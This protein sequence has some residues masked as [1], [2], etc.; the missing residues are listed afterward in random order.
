M[1]ALEA[2]KAKRLETYVKKCRS[3]LE[4]KGW[5]DGL[6]YAAETFLESVWGPMFEYNF[7]SGT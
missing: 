2:G 3:Q 1:E 4:A 5:E 7:R 6:S